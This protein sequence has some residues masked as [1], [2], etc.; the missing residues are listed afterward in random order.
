M[1]QYSQDELLQIIKAY[2]STD[3]QTI[4]K[5]LQILKVK[6]NFKNADIIADL[7]HKVEKVRGWFSMTNQ[8]IPTFEDALGLAVHYGFDI[9]ELT[10]KV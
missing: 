7:G 2:N 6:Y 9:A 10:E 3:K 1:N 4:K 5:N 8:Y